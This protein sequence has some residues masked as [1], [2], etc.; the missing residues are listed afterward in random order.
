MRHIKRK[1]NDKASPST[2]N[3]PPTLKR[4]RDTTAPGSDS[5]SSL[6]ERAGPS[7]YQKKAKTIFSTEFL[8]VFCGVAEVVGMGGVGGS[9]ETVESDSSMQVE[10]GER[11]EVESSSSQGE[12]MA[13]TSGEVAASSGVATSSQEEALRQ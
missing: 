10:V 12:N 5:Q 2:A 9:Q 11:R 3:V 8:Q 6:E 13:G 4:A 1:H 7:G